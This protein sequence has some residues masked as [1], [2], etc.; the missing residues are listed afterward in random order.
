MCLTPDCIPRKSRHILEPYVICLESG[1]KIKERDDCESV[2]EVFNMT[3][4]RFE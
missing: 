2:E 4:R 3:L 1:W